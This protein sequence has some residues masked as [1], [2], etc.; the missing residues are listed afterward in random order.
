MNLKKEAPINFEPAYSI[1]HNVVCQNNY[2]MTDVKLQNDDLIY[3]LSAWPGCYG[4]NLFHMNV[5]NITY[6]IEI[7]KIIDKASIKFYIVLNWIS[8]EL[9]RGRN[10][11][12][13]PSSPI[14]Q[15]FMQHKTSARSQFIKHA[16]PEHKNSRPPATQKIAIKNEFAFETPCSR[17]PLRKRS[18][19]IVRHQ[20]F[21]ERRDWKKELEG[22]K[23]LMVYDGIDQR[24]FD[25]SCKIKWE[26]FVN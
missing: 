17:P 10:N 25:D 15:I 21:F 13:Q 6:I 7:I 12:S 1:C 20:V 14:I 2:Q 3:N 16:P 5:Q 18:A 19:Q 11:D 24:L 23:I 4:G 8:P 26:K 9:L 22:K